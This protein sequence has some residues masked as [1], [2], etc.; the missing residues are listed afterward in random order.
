MFNFL[1]CFFVLFL[2]IIIVVFAFLGSIINIILSFLGIKKRV[3]NDYTR[4][5]GYDRQGSAYG[6]RDTYDRGQG[7]QQDEQTNYDNGQQR[8]TGQQTGKIFE[9][10]ESEYVD[11][12]EIK[13]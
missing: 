13:S 3:R 2:G 12:E 4:T 7:R 5:G 1:G 8:S 11:F 6:S 9:K 10:D